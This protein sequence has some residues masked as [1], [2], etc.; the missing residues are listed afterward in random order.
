VP[1]IYMLVAKRRTA[2]AGMPALDEAPAL[3]ASP[4]GASPAA[5]PLLHEGTHV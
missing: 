1:S 3:P 5:Q 4:F 2:T